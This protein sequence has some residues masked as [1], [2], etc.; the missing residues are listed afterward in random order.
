MF[1]KNRLGLR[2]NLDDKGKVRTEA[3]MELAG[4]K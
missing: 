3:E 2:Y 4:K 1:K